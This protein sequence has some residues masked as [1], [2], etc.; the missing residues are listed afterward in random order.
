LLKEFSSLHLV[1]GQT[2][3]PIVSYQPFFN[4]F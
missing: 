3:E 1:E 2:L 4:S